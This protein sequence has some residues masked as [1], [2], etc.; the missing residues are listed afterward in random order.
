LGASQLSTTSENLDL[1]L[2]K[3]EASRCLLATIAGVA[4]DIHFPEC[5]RVSRHG[6]SDSLRGRMLR[7]FFFVAVV[8]REQCAVADVVVKD[9]EAWSL[10]SQSSP[11]I[12]TRSPSL[13]GVVATITSPPFASHLTTAQE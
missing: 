6:S 7:R 10:F 2:P 5:G 8:G 13:N 9:V 4:L 11:P 12:A 1:A 3:P